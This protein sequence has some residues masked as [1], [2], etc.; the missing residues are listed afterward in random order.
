MSELTKEFLDARPQMLD[1]AKSLGIER[2]F[3]IDPKSPI[4]IIVDGISKYLEKDNPR[5]VFDCNGS[6][7]T[8]Y[9]AMNVRLGSCF[10]SERKILFKFCSVDIGSWW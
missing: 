9:I 8:N 2:L 1:Q 10:D 5:I 3:L 4:P 6:S 7:L